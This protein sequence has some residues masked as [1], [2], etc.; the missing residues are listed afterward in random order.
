VQ[1]LFELV[2][3]LVD[4][5]SVT[6]SETA[7]SA[8][9]E[10]RLRA[11]GFVVETQEV[12]P[13]RANIIATLGTPE[14]VLSTHIDT[15]R[16]YFPSSE[17]ANW[18]RGRGACDAKGILACQMI[19]A[20]QLA[21][22]GVGDLGLLFVVGEESQSDG[23]RAA[24][25]CP[26]GSRYLIVG[27][28][29]DNRLVTATKGVLQLRVRARGRAAHSAYPELGE[30]AIEKLLDALNSLRAMPLPSD[31]ELGPATMNIGT[32]SGG[33]A[34]NVVPESAEAMMLFRTVDDCSALM[35]R[36][37]AL[38]DGRV[39]YEF[40][41]FA[42]ATRLQTV[43]GFETSTVSFVSDVGNLGRWGQPLLIGPGSIQVAHTPEERV[44]KAE[45][46][47]AVKLYR[48][49]VRELKLRARTEGGSQ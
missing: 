8:F 26:R 6:G 25:E 28:P 49:L 34:P 44:S 47:Q 32:I 17:D 3:R 36:I 27:E 24:N 16:P 45:L 33:V 13:G 5:N 40:E 11:A 14:V 46:V 7:C 15:V 43:E 37:G 12:S 48:G 18:I 20:E 38:L 35:A 30:S 22:E 21:R 23:A 19:A 42:A 39:E 1:E 10:S 41:R 4:I 29:T 2:R 9:L 31:P